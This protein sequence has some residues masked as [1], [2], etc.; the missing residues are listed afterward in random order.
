MT[1]VT[2]PLRARLNEFGEAEIAKF[3]GA[4]TL[5]KTDAL[6]DN[7]LHVPVIVIV[8]LPTDAALLAVRVS[9]LTLVVLLGLNAA[10]T[11]LGR[12]EVERLTLLLKPLS[13]LMVI[14][15]VPFA[16]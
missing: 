2:F 3:G 6:C 9:V 4:A 15:L 8:K 7:P 12:P 10:V 16:P 14:V 11:P 13:G 1:E 5:S